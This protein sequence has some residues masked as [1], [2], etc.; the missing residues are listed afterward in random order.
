MAITLSRAKVVNEDGSRTFIKLPNAR[1]S[2]HDSVEYREDIHKGKL[3]CD[4]CDAKVH[5]VSQSSGLVGSSYYSPRPELFALNPG[6]KH[7]CSR[8]NPNEDNERHFYDVASGLRVHLNIPNPSGEF[9][10]RT[11]YSR[12]GRKWRAQE[13][14]LPQ[15]INADKFQQMETVSASSISDLLDL[16]EKADLDRLSKSYLVAGHRV[17]PFRDFV[18]RGDASKEGLGSRRFQR[19]LKQL[20]SEPNRNGGL[21]RMV[22]LSTEKSIISSKDKFP[23]VACKAMFLD[24]LEDGPRFIIPHIDLDLTRNKFLGDTFREAGRYSI[25]GVVRSS[26]MR[27]GNIGMYVKVS[28]E[29]QIERRTPSEI[30]KAR[31]ELPLPEVA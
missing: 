13:N 16:M 2:A 11:L 27:N 7:T 28:D 19:F 12:E 5:Y 17:I 30:M 21:P 23:T 9:N 10:S 14:M 3:I 1:Y 6:Q 20:N 25:M 8:P 18:L 4:C 26:V 29:R 15:G 24:R 22:E 31:S